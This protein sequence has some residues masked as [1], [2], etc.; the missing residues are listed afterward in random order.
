[1][2][3]EE[4][5][6][7]RSSRPAGAGARPV[8]GLP[9]KRALSAASHQNLDDLG[10]KSVTG[11]EKACCSYLFSPRTGPPSFLRAHCGMSM[12]LQPTR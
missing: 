6:D 2:T 1:M 5:T 11:A 4:G 10:P 9:A 3:T 12:A 8:P 7:R